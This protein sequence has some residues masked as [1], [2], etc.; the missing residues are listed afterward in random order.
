MAIIIG[1]KKPVQSQGVY[2]KRMIRCPG[3]WLISPKVDIY[4]REPVG[5][6]KDCSNFVEYQGKRVKINKMRIVKDKWGNKVVDWKKIYEIK[7]RQP[8]LVLNPRISAAEAI[9]RVWDP[10]SPLCQACPKYCKEGQGTISE[11]AIK[12]LHK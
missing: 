9:E 2:Y 10:M 1:E 11:Y 8:H 6:L 4:K 7:K 3:H 12:R 5:L